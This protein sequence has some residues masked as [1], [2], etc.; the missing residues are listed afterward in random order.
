M[1][2]SDVSE[3]L[4]VHIHKHPVFESVPNINKM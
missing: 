4:C 2:R 3:C 1:N